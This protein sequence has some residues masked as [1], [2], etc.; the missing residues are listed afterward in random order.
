MFKTKERNKD[1]VFVDSIP[2][3]P[4]DSYRL[5]SDDRF[6]MKLFVENGRRI[7][8]FGADIND[9]LSGQTSS[10]ARGSTSISYKV[11]KNGEVE[12]P[13]LGSVKL[14]GLTV[15]E[16]QELLKQYYSES[17]IDPFIQLEVTNR[18][19]IVFPGSGGA[20]K[21]IPIENDNTTLMEVL[22]AAGGIT[23]RG[24]ANNIKI[25]RQTDKGREVYQLDLSVLEGLQYADMIVQADDYIY[26]EPTKQLSR[27]F[28][29]ELSPI[30][31][32]ITT[33]VMIIT[34]VLSFK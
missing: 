7:I 32:I 31:S 4:E 1:M 24:K 27:E 18:R 34:L 2:M 17:Y 12:L 5:A 16:A 28:L 6:T 19:V 25:M 9:G 14:G 23:E 8:D 13:I 15:I 30:V 22:A 21:V 20:A 33:T 10:M 26:V 11:R 29:K 3:S